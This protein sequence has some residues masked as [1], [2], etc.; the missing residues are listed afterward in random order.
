MM[1]ERFVNCPPPLLIELFANLMADF[2][3]IN[4]QSKDNK[5]PE[6]IR[7]IEAFCSMN[8]VLLVS[9]C[10]ESPGL[11]QQ[12]SDGQPVVWDECVSVE[13][14][15]EEDRS[16]AKRAKVALLMRLNQKLFLPQFGLV[17]LISIDD[18]RQAISTIA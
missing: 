1:S 3:W 13:L 17:L 4:S 10:K 18:L 9:P 16:F 5:S 14:K 7:V 11:E 8:Y 12:L 6:D 2:D 15:R